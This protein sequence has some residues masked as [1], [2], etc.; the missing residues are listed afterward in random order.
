MRQVPSNA[1]CAPN[2]FRGSKP[3]ALFF[4]PTIVLPLSVSPLLQADVI[5]KWPREV[6]LLTLTS[7]LLH[8]HLKRHEKRGKPG[9]AMRETGRRA[10]AATPEDGTVKQGS[11]PPTPHQQKPVRQTYTPV[12]VPISISS[13]PP[14]Y[15]AMDRGWAPGIDTSRMRY[16]VNS[17]NEQ[18]TAVMQAQFSG[19]PMDGVV[20][21]QQQMMHAGW[22]A[23]GN[24]VG[25][26]GAE[27]PWP[28]QDGG[29]F[30]MA[31]ET[32]PELTPGGE[33]LDPFMEEYGPVVEQ[34]I[35]FVSIDLM[36]RR[37]CDA[38]ML[39]V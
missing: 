29:I 13:L 26:T 7:D 14:V 28:F 2:S 12:A 36:K 3:C 39:I 9:A 31:A 23:V 30:G 5:Y 4:S 18:H 11:P 32:Y 17:M 27:F 38:D 33:F 35:G 22:A 15:E 6:G 37:W 24:G 16:E 1:A 8:A 34:G 19:A 10:V 21:A 25:A 20:S